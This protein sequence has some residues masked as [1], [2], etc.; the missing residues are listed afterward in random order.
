MC[1]KLLMHDGQKE[2]SRQQPWPNTTG[3]EACMLNTKE[4]CQ[5]YSWLAASDA[6]VWNRDKMLRNIKFMSH[7]FNNSLVSET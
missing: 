7:L 4:K 2:R 5:M 1:V 3:P 6:D